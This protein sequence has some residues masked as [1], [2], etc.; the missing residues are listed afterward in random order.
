VATLDPRFATAAGLA[1]IQRQIDDAQYAQAVR[2][3]RVVDGYR[4][5]IQAR[6][7]GSSGAEGGRSSAP[8]DVDSA[9]GAAE[10][11]RHEAAVVRYQRLERAITGYGP[12][13]A[14][15]AALALD[16]RAQTRLNATVRFC[17]EA[18]LP[19]D[20]A[21]MA[22]DGLTRLARADRKGA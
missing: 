19:S 14:D 4:L 1:C 6:G 12:S 17:T 21:A 15:R 11:K 7:I 22:K 9:A 3:A 13:E 8:I 2:L 18:I 10:A 5:A 16:R 20:E